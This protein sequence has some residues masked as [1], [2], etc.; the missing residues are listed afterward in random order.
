MFSAADV[1]KKQNETNRYVGMLA[2]LMHVLWKGLLKV[3]WPSTFGRYFCTGVVL[4]MCSPPPG[5]DTQRPS[6]PLSLFYRRRSFISA[7]PGGEGFSCSGVRHRYLPFLLTNERMHKVFAET[8]F[9]PSCFF[10]TDYE[11]GG[12]SARNKAKHNTRSTR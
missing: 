11:V 1:T 7:S 5:S 9:C 4:Q 12:G 8:L 3:T 2:K 10:R 6:Y